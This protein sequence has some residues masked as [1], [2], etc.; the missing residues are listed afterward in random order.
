MSELSLRIEKTVKTI[1]CVFF[2]LN[3]YINVH[4]FE[5]QDTNQDASIIQ[6]IEKLNSFYS[7]SRD[8]L[9]EISVIQ[10]LDDYMQNRTR[11]SEFIQH[12]STHVFQKSCD[13]KTL[14][15]DDNSLEENQSTR[16]TS[17]LSVSIHHDSTMLE[18]A[19]LV[20]FCHNLS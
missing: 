2:E 10:A 11:S 6:K 14:E 19:F 16:I 12:A 3:R 13:K 8:A 20:S 7:Y 18:L 5:N 1:S 9:C 4:V 15:T 17:D